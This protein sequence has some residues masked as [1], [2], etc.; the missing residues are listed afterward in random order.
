VRRSNH[1]GGIGRRRPTASGGAR[2]TRAST[3]CLALEQLR[4]TGSRG[5]RRSLILRDARLAPLQEPLDARGYSAGCRLAH[6]TTARNLRR[7]QIDRFGLEPF[8]AVLTIE[9]ELGFGKT[10]E[11]CLTGLAA[12]DVVEQ[13][14]IRRQP[15]LGHRSRGASGVHTVGVDVRGGGLPA[16]AVLTA[17]SRRSPT[18]ALPFDGTEFNHDSYRP[19]VH[20]VQQVRVY[21]I[22][23]D[24]E[25][26]DHMHSV[27]KMVAHCASLVRARG[28]GLRRSPRNTKRG[29]A[30]RR[31]TTPRLGRS[32]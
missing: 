26:G 29:G 10:A 32:N 25:Q 3:S 12:C 16:T 9:G 17:P 7:R 2:W 13:R 30:F 8:D 5:D 19:Q 20:P 18:C 15:A 6:P 31:R 4:R 28:A 23:P 22:G 21:A 11:G 1:H 24:G 14:Q 27:T